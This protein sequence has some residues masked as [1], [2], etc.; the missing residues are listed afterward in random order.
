MLFMFILEGSLYKTVFTGGPYY[1]FN[2]IFVFTDVDL[3]Y[4]S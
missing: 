1:D 3:S 4:S 2:L